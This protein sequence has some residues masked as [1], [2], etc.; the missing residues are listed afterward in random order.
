V[1]SWK[2]AGCPTRPTLIL[3]AEDWATLDE[4]D[5]DSLSLSDDE[6]ALLDWDPEIGDELAA[7]GVSLES[8]ASA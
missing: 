8:L 4:V 7:M 2:T 3:T 6:I 1:P 5:P